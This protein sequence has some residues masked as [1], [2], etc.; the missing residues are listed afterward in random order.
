MPVVEI[1]ARCYSGK[2]IVLRS[3]YQLLPMLNAPPPQT[4]HQLGT[5]VHEVLCS[6]LLDAPIPRNIRNT[7]EQRIVNA[8][9]DTLTVLRRV[10]RLDY[11]LDARV[12]SWMHL[13]HYKDFEFH[14]ALAERASTSFYS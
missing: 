2:I 5:Q 13:A 6:W 9:A 14:E 12:L 7:R 10:S 11:G 4:V 1:P 3:L 8:H